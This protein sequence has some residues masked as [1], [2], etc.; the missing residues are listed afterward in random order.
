MNLA[1]DGMFYFGVERAV[2]EKK[3]VVVHSPGH[4][5]IPA[6]SSRLIDRVPSSTRGCPNTPTGSRPPFWSRS[7]R[8][9]AGR[10]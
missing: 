8:A 2:L 6:G 5:G 9:M 7:N 10:S 3:G 4:M 1:V